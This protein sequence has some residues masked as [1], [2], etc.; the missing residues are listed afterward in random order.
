M[1]FIANITIVNDYSKDGRLMVNFTNSIG[2]NQ[3]AMLDNESRFFELIGE[4]IDLM[5]TEGTQH[6]QYGKGF[7]ELADGTI[8]KVVSDTR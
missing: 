7:T 4:A 2:A 8:T 1:K 6:R 5:E 3:S